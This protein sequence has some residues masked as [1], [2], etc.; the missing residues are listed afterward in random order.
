MARLSLGTLLALA[1][2]APAA[3]ADNPPAANRPAAQPSQTPPSQTQ[4]TTRDQ[5][6]HEAGPHIVTIETKLDAA[7]AENRGLERLVG[8]ESGTLGRTYQEHVGV[9][10]TSIQNDLNTARQHL[11][12]LRD[13]AQRLG[14]M[15][16]LNDQFT[17]VD[18]AMQQTRVKLAAINRVRQQASPA[19]SEIRGLSGDIGREL[20]QAK[21][22]VERIESAMR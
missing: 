4:N 16:Q 18:Q 20:A 7:S 15:D 21:S 11:D 12:H 5:Q 17:R 19:S 8:L 1:L 13:S 14:M 6:L 3:H 9:L 22:A 10:A 2:A